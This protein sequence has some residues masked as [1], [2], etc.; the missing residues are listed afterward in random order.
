MQSTSTATTI[1]TALQELRIWQESVERDLSEGQKSFNLNKAINTQLKANIGALERTVGDLTK[2]R[3]NAQQA[4]EQAQRSLDALGDV[5]DELS[6]ETKQELDS[7]ISAADSAITTKANQ[8]AGLIA[9]VERLS[10]EYAS[11]ERDLE[12]KEAALQAALSDLQQPAGLLTSLAGLIQKYR[13]DLKLAVEA[14]QVRK[15]YVLSKELTRIKAELDTL[16]KPEHEQQLV[17]AYSSAREALD[18]QRSANQH[19]RQEL[20]TK[21]Q[22]LSKTKAELKSLKS[23]REKQIKALFLA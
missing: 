1:E 3:T 5:L 14:G 12:K 13:T 8:L 11:S 23:E 6:D 4:S 7:V 22:A 18:A 17:S 15:A 20:E 21:Q 2:A 16:R 10:D 19:K 9:D